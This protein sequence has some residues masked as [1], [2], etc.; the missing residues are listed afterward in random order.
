MLMFQKFLF[1]FFINNTIKAAKFQYLLQ[2]EKRESV[3]RSVKAILIIKL[4]SGQCRILS[5]I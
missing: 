4:K 2:K 3:L 1:R 5:G